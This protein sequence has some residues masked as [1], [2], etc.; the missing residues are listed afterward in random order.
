MGGGIVMPQSNAKSVIEC[1]KSY[2]S[3]KQQIEQL[4]FELTTYSAVDE[5]ELI[6]SLALGTRLEGVSNRS[7][8]HLSDKTMA[9]ALK[10]KK[11]KEE[12]EFESKGSIARQLRVLEAE[13]DRLEYYV[14]LLDKQKAAVIRLRYFEKK[15][16][17]D[18]EAELQI[19]QR[20]IFRYRKEAVERLEYMYSLLDR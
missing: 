14:S 3:I 7:S 13:I 9:I 16:W 12:M 11:I 20:T 5:N 15:S 2:T 4:R 18:I 1:L 17:P 19:S 8:S 6:E 10:Y